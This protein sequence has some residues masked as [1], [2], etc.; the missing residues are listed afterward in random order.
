MSK[1]PSAVW[2]Q[3]SRSGVLPRNVCVCSCCGE[4][5]LWSGRTLSIT[6]WKSI[7]PQ[8]LSPHVQLG[9]S[10]MFSDLFCRC[11]LILVGWWRLT[12]RTRSTQP[13]ESSHPDA[14]LFSYFFRTT[15]CR[16]AFQHGQKTPKHPLTSGSCL[17][18]KWKHAAFTLG[19]NDSA[20][21]TGFLNRLQLA[22]M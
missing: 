18:W 10:E 8:A 13:L 15:L 6:H 2:I 19:S 7:T 20:V 9:V 4:L 3:H 5:W 14:G 1:H 16:T 21:D 12:W 22:G 11:P 17:Q